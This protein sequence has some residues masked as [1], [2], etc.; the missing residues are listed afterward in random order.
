MENRYPL[1]SGGR[2]LKKES[3]WDVR[4]YAYGGWQLFYADY[5]DGLLSGCAIRVED[6]SLVI[7]KGMLKYNGFVYLL[8]EE[9]KVAYEPQNRWVCLK[10]EFCEEQRNLDYKSYRVRFF[11]DTALALEENQMELCRFYLRDGSVLRDGYR[12]FSDMAT[13][14]DTVNLI[15]ATVAGVGWQ[16]LH[17]ALLWQF[18][19]ELSQM[20]GKEPPDYALC[21]TVWNEC[22]KTGRKTILMYLTDKGRG[23]GQPE[24]SGWDNE[25]I[26]MEMQHIL[27]LKKRKNGRESAKKMMV[28]D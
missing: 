17:P 12:D 28:L 7:G 21:Y 25:K 4:D 5:T 23:T 14:Y 1:F 15:H 20:G 6:N 26:Y 13:E 9:M 18:A 2:I 24:M 8:Y 3:L 22:G 10:A 16:T 27:N 11:I 19:E